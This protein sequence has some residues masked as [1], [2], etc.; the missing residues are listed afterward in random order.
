MLYDWLVYATS[1]HQLELRLC[2]SSAPCVY[3]TNSN[4]KRLALV[5]REQTTGQRQV[6]PRQVSSR[7]NTRTYLLRRVW[8]GDFTFKPI[9]CCCL[10]LCTGVAAAASR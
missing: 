7:E 3:R 4:T 6:T 8:C 1:L 9:C 2:S 5:A 10:L